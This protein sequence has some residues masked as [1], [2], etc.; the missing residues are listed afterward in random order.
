MQPEN[1]NPRFQKI[2]F[3]L[4]AV[5]VG[6]FALAVI[7]GIS[8]FRAEVRHQI[9]NRDGSLLT[10]IAQ[11]MHESQERPE[12]GPWQFVELALD[13]SEIRGII[14][15]RIFHPLEEL[16]QQVPETLY[17]VSLSPQDRS[18]LA[19][20]KP[21]V[22]FFEEI[23]L[24]ALFSDLEEI[25]ADDASPVV[26][27]LAPIVDSTGRVQAAIQY[28][29]D[30]T[31]VAAEFALVDQYLTG[32]GTAFIFG[33]IIIFSIVFL[34]ARRR[35]IGMAGLLAERNRSLQ[36][37]NAEL[38]LAARTSAIGSVTSHLF[39]GLKNP[40]AGLKAYLQLTTR[41]EEALAIAD[42]M[43]SLINE[44]LAVIRD[45]DHGSEIILNSEEFSEMVSK[46][47]SGIAANRQQQVQIRQSGS[48]SISSK[49]TQ[50][51]LLVL[52]NLVDNACEASPEGHEVTIEMAWTE[53]QLQLRVRDAGEGLP[54][55]VKAN[56]FEPVMSTK[57]G[58]TGVGLAISSVLARHIPATL[59]LESSSGQGTI[60]LIAV[61]T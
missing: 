9:L 12:L 39:H 29:L 52:S 1:D 19:S 16:L 5:V 58:G 49:K 27:V 34:Y 4:G 51:L 8:L 59:E 15:V 17:P 54:Q 28:W 44:T 20:E 55:S 35:L 3:G 60:F 40:L 24:D 6:V 47:L 46:R 30:G 21:I 61:P 18:I 31:E 36:K 14:A 50:L 13:S 37:A 23:R 56:L 43:Q 10:N 25:D 22:R 41:D 42:R 57:A 2:F 48:G 33:G 45:Q 26:E 32:M 38:V 11:Y 7:L 53:G